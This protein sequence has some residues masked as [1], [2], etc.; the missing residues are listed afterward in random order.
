[1]RSGT[2]QPKKPT[3][4]STQLTSRHSTYVCYTN[5]V[6][7]PG[8]DYSPQPGHVVAFQAPTNGGKSIALCQATARALTQG[9][10]VDY[11][12]N[13][14]CGDVR[15]RQIVSARIGRPWLYLSVDVALA[16]SD[17][18]PVGGSLHVRNSAPGALFNLAHLSSNVD[19]ICVDTLNR[20]V[21]H[22]WDEDALRTRVDQYTGA[23]M[24]KGAGLM[25]AYHHPRTMLTPRENETIVVLDWDDDR[26]NG[27]WTIFTHN[28]VRE[29]RVQQDFC[30][31]IAA[32]G[33]RTEDE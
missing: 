29:I 17:A 1:M 6:Q 9:L 22:S 5:D 3:D 32:A 19:M 18:R 21:V 33:I 23:A 27:T 7:I 28:T 11:I 12:E 26:I 30:H 14:A 15:I 8:I 24:A 16:A 13:E 25:V 10:N 2:A 31:A 20:D 4:V